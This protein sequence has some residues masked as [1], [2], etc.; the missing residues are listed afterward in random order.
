MRKAFCSVGFFL[1]VSFVSSVVP[2]SAAEK[3][4]TYD[5]H[6]AP[7]FRDKCNACHDQDKA[8]G[9]LILN[10]Y[11]KMMEGGSSGEVVK[12]GDADGSRLFLLV[13]HKQQPNM[14]PKAPMI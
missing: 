11:T 2:S 7:I 4:L 1:F 9:G 8:K 12:P 5:E 13:S 14:P 6:V 3:K 10:N